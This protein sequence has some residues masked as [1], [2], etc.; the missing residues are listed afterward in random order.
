MPVAGTRNFS[1]TVAK[2]F[3]CVLYCTV[4]NKQHRVFGSSTYS[5]TIVTGSRLP[6]DIDN[7]KEGATSL[8]PLFKRA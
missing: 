8:L 3:D 2:Y 4:L 5:P 6:I 7:N 1:L